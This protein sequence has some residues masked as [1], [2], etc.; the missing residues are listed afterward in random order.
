MAPLNSV[1]GYLASKGDTAHYNLCG[2]KIYV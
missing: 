2:T 1:D